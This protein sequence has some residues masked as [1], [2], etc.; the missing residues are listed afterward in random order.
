MRTSSHRIFEPFFT[1]KDIGKGTGMGLSMVHGI[2]HDH[3]G[4]AL[5][6]SDPGKGTTMRI[7]L[8]VGEG[9]AAATEGPAARAREATD[10]RL[11]G[12]VLVVDDNV[13]VSEYIEDLLGSWGMAVT[14]FNDSVAARDHV[15]GEPGAYDLIIT[16]QTM[17][18]LTGLELAREIA[19]TAPAL[20]IFLYTG[21]SESVSEDAA[22]AAGIRAFL[23]KPLDTADLRAKIREVL[24]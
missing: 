15:L 20:P 7:F 18:R 1:T 12:R 19:A 23:P 2:V 24:G 6:D 11:P 3:G 4:H 22:L 10:K 9:G 21:Y 17:P 5:V 13:E 16:D 8:P 14:V